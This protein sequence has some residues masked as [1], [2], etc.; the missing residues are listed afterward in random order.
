M[1]I[2][3]ENYLIEVI[4]RMNAEQNA[5]LEFIVDHLKINLC[6][7]YILKL[8]QMSMDAMATNNKDKPQEA[9]KQ[10]KPTP[11]LNVVDSISKANKIKQ[12]PTLKVDGLASPASQ[13]AV[14]PLFE[15]EEIVKQP[16]LN[17]EGKIN[18]PEVVL[19]AQPE[20]LNSKI[21]IMNVC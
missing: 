21:L 8:Y 2:S 11:K 13:T 17:V 15:N 20:K 14:N 10:P 16:T 6:L 4:Y 12:R 9:E 19:F 5:K 18:I 7:P 1:P 3:K